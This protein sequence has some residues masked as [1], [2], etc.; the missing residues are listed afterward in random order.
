MPSLRHAEDDGDAWLEQGRL[1]GDVVFCGLRRRLPP[2]T[3]LAYSVVRVVVFV[4]PSYGRGRWMGHQGW[5]DLP[6]LPMESE[7][8]AFAKRCLVA[9]AVL[10]PL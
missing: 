8:D 1:Y 10:V 3:L 6:F 7:I 5:Q 4:P 9:S 2:F